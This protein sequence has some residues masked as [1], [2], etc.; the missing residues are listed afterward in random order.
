[1]GFKMVKIFSTSGNPLKVKCQG[2]TVKTLM[3][4]ISKNGTR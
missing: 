1:M 3:S 4:N 2:K